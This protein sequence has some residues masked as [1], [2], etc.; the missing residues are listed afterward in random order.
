MKAFALFLLF[1][2]VGFA[3]VKPEFVKV[4]QP[5]RDHGS[6]RLVQIHSVVCWDSNGA[7]ATT[8]APLITAANKVP[9]NDSDGADDLN[10]ASLASLSVEH[11]SSGA[12]P[13]VFLVDLSKAKSEE[14]GSS[15]PEVFRATLE[16][17]RLIFPKEIKKAEI[18]FTIPVGMPGCRRIADEFLKHDQ[19]KPF[20]IQLE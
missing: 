11:E 8:K 20:F 18:R 19:S 17:L 10:L 2:N 6:E 12:G 14:R 7:G 15:T 4:F 3:E 9:T 16:C 1:L 5:L 13:D